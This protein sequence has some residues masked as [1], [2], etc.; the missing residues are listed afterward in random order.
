[1][2]KFTLTAALIVA[3][4]FCSAQQASIVL[5]VEGVIKAKG[6][7]LSAGIFTNGNFP[8]IGKEFKEI[9]QAVT[10]SV[11]QIVFTDIPAGTYAVAVFQDI[12]KDKKL[13]T[14]WTG[15]PAEPIGFSNDARI[16]LGPPSMKQAAVNL[17]ENQK[18]VLKIVLH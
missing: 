10:D 1:M 5:N 3:A 17:A 6:G 18:L 15:M 11:M 2:V 14:R 9:K 12:D 8:I 16:V 7:E 13:K 4:V